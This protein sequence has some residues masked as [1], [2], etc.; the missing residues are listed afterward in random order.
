MS[1]PIPIVNINSIPLP[2]FSARARREEPTRDL[3]NARNLEVQR[4]GPPVFQGFFRPEPSM[5][6]YAA[7]K[8]AAFN[9]QIGVP[10]RNQQPTSI[11]APPFDPK[12]AKLD[13]NPYFDQYAPSYDPRN[14]AR[15]LQGSVKEDKMDRGIAESQ[16]LLERGFTS[17]YVPEG[18]AQRNQLNSLQ[19]FESLRPK[20]DDPH[21]V[22]RSY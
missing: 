21:K 4:S 22:Y 8:T 15:E 10:S 1:V 11:P 19:A 5:P 18:F 13:G 16:R 6:T 7:R 20:I 2:E 12:G 3:V 17:R 9:D 14:V